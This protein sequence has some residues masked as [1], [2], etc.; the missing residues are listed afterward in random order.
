[1]ECEHAKWQ[2]SMQCHSKNPMVDVLI[3]FLH[4]LSEIKALIFQFMEGARWQL[5]ESSSF[6]GL[7]QLKLKVLY[8]MAHIQWHVCSGV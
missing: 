1:M 6:W 3:Y 4:L 5:S 8:R 2:F 7:L